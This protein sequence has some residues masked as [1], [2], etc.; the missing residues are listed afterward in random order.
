VHFRAGD[1]LMASACLLGV[2]SVQLLARW[3]LL[4]AYDQDLPW[5][6]LLPA[7]WVPAMGK[8]VVSGFVSVGGAVVMLRSYGIPAAIA[9]SVTVLIDALAVLAGFIVSTPLLLWGPLHQRLPTAW[10][11]CVL[12]SIF[13]VILLHPRIFVSAV[14]LALRRFGRQTIDQ[15]PATARYLLPLLASFG[16][17]LFAGL[18]LWFM[19]AAVMD[20]SINLIPLF[21][22]SS[23]LATTIG[24]LTPFAPGGI[25]V[26]EG[27][28]LLTLGPTIGPNVAI[29]A[30][31]MRLVQTLI[32]VGLA[33]VGLWMMKARPANQPKARVL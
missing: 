10:A 8:Y 3:G 19:T 13:G 28:Y 9:L 18:S 26:R 5:R 11:G 24:Y 7:A 14:N 31:A 27:L 16:Q 22:A 30:L 20:V 33:L 29:V 12:V 25:G 6:L 4:R 1:V 17:W 15:T 23:A 2:A 32:E 21:I